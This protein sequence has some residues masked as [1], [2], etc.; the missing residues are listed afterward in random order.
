MLIT[1][2]MISMF[3]FERIFLIIYYI[4]IAYMID[5][6][7]TSNIH[8]VLY[9]NPKYN[10]K[11]LHLFILLLTHDINFLFFIS[12]CTYLVAIGALLII[13]SLSFFS[14]RVFISDYILFLVIFKFSFG[15]VIY[16]VY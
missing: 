7:L 2:Y 11:I 6:P 1:D 16:F 10:L 14:L 12:F 15:L 3:P 8:Y 9:H 13:C 4:T 5:F